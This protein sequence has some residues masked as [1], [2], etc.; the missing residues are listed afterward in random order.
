MYPAK[1]SARVRSLFRFIPTVRKAI[2]AGVLG[3]G[4]GISTAM[5]DGDLTRKEGIIA[6]GLGLGAGLA[7]YRVPNAA[8][9]PRDP[10]EVP[11]IHDVS[12]SDE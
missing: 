11:E 4:G 8:S 7:T 1:H 5:L 9:E 12:F 10:R 2:I 6:L 3:A